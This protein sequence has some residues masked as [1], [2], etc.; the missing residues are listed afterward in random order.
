MPR[1]FDRLR[2]RRLDEDDFQD[3]IRAHLAIAEEERVADGADRETAHYG[4]LKDFGNVTLATED[5]R[6]VW[7]PWWVE[8][9]HD[10]LD[11]V[12]YATRALAKNPVF[13]LTVIGVLALGIGLNAAVFTM[14]KSMALAPLAGVQGSSRLAVVYAET[15]SGRDLAVSYPDYLYLRD[16]DRSFA[17]LFGSRVASVNL[18]RGRGSRQIFTEFV[19]GNYFQVLGVRAA[20]GRTLLPSDDVAPGGHPVIVLSHTLW[21]T[22]FASAPDIVGKTVEINNCQFTVAGVADQTFHGTIVSYDVE[23]FIPVMMAPTLGFTLGSDQTT[24]AGVM[25][26]RRAAVVYPQGFLRAGT[27]L[28]TAASETEA[29][30]T[31]VSREHSMT[32]AAQRIRVVRFWQ[33]PGSAQTH[34]LPTL[35]V[36]CAMGLLVLTIACANIA[37]LVL[38]RGVSRRG[39]IAVRLA[40]G[41]TRARIVRLLVVENLVLAVPGAVVGVLLAQQ[42]IPILVGYAERMA[43]PEHIFFNIDLDALVIGFAALV[44]CGCALLF[45]F[46]PALQSSRVDLVSVINEDASPR[47]ASRGRLRAALVIAQVA[48]SLLLL[49][50]AGL[51]TRSLD[52]ARR[53]DPG[54]DV[55]H[56]TAVAMDVRQNAYDERRG[57]QFYR[58]LLDGARTDP[59]VE[60]A[61]LAVYLPLAFL[62]TR[63]QRVTIDGYALRR[64]EDLAFL[65]NTVGPDYFRTLR[66]PIVAGREFAND[67]DE[68]AAPAAIVNTTLARRF[69]GDPANA[70]GKRIRAGSG[71]WR[72]VVGVATDVKYLQINEAPRPYYYLP[73]FQSYK[74]GMILHTRGPAP[75][76]RLVDQ[77]R[78]RVAALDPDLPILFARSLHESTRG[79]LLFF[80]LTAAMLFLFGV[81]GMALAAMG[82]YGLVWYIVKQST[83]EIG[84]RIALGAS[85]PSVVR[86]FLARGVRLGAIGSAVGIVSALGLTR[87]LSGVLFGVSATD[88]TS[89][90]RALAVVLGGV[91]VAT[92]VPAWR[93]SRTDPLRALRHQ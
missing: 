55:L 86:E 64:G 78:T 10:Q 28:A 36:L 93:A 50:G 17:G 49:I 22:D 14:V 4:A 70:I 54:F 11:D 34:M 60:S 41:A 39:E 37:G 62:E 6:R 25:A 66:I 57:R 43:A 32:D 58:H 2:Q 85:S 67:D 29:L 83:H 31:T 45:G 8:A 63:A 46:V 82:T 24:P 77:A 48:V 74:S 21:R 7:M 38:V 56:V 20:R 1:W 79:A 19:T 18:G 44:A 72:T 52:V 84:I 71:D 15:S 91:V 89:F 16:H 88:L 33:F 35:T 90:A 76:D 73:F 27:S 65:S 12:R 69:W 81:A 9:L 51:A 13:S 42:G 59:G 68:N 47:G 75:I 30:W 80:E 26:D 3:E 40:L 23:A 92:I 53:T 87:L 61:T 5:A